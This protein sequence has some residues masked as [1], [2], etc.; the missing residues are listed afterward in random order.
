MIRP[1]LPASAGV[2]AGP[3]P[4]VVP[5]QEA[6][7]NASPGFKVPEFRDSALAEP[8]P[9]KRSLVASLPVPRGIVSP[10]VGRSTKAEPAAEK[11]VA[12]SDG[13]GAERPFDAV[14]QNGPIFKDDLGKPWPKPRL[15]LVITGRQEGYFEP[16]GCA[17]LER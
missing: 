3:A 5:G 4:V 10:D 16:C 1:P 2:P 14:T 13:G 6:V 12:R 17:G 15:A 7:A 11:P 9:G 8:L